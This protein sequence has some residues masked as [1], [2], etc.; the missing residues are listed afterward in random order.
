MKSSSLYGQLD[1]YLSVSQRH[2]HVYSIFRIYIQRMP[3]CLKAWSRL[4]CFYLNLL[5]PVKNSVG[6]ACLLVI[7]NFIPSSL[8]SPSSFFSASSKTAHHFIHP[9]LTIKRSREKYLQNP[10]NYTLC[11][12]G[13]PIEPHHPFWKVWAK[14]FVLV[15]TAAFGSIRRLWLLSILPCCGLNLKDRKRKGL[16]QNSAVLSTRRDECG[17]CWQNQSANALK[18]G[19]Y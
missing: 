12:C 4:S 7:I 6:K 19:Y 8:L 1:G 17:I 15:I 13:S 9:V 2:T 3:V 14:A 18:T 10:E 11:I 16:V 5:S